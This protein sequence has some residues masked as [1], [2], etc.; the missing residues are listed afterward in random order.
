MIYGEELSDLIIK[1]ITLLPTEE[2]GYYTSV[3]S[4]RS[5]HFTKREY[6]TKKGKIPQSYWHIVSM[7]TGEI[8]NGAIG[9]LEK[10]LEGADDGPV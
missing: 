5:F 6:S 2:G 3:L 8:F 4:N 7:Q 10:A 9:K 1:G